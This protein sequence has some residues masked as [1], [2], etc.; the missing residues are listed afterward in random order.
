MSFASTKELTRQARADGYAVPAVN[1]VDGISI[2]AVVAAADEAASPIILQTSVK[3]VKYFGAAVLAATAQAAA[4]AAR[5]PVALHLDHCPDRA[6]I[7]ET[8]AHGWSSVLFDASD[9]PLDEAWAQTREVVAEAH[10][11]G[12]DVETE[13]EN[14]VG[15]E[16][17]IGSDDPNVHYYSDE[18]LIAVAH[19]TGSDL[20]A[21]ALGTAHGLYTAAPVLLVDRVKS[22]SAQS[23]IS[24]VLHGGTGL[25]PDEFTAFIDAGVSK[26]NI[27]T[28]LKLAYMHSARD[29]LAEAE[30]TG[31]WEPVKLFDQVGASVREIVAQHIALF[32]SAQRIGVPA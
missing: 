11:A 25:S 26:I 23:D 6:V 8:I 18:Q 1:I 13:I 3:T 4:D 15:V 10:A 29:H 30:R 28:A 9:R 16:D 2:A 5:V 19:D 31:K 24:I 7:T 32:G 21:P 12:V 14:I 22:L 27:S 17:G 20:I